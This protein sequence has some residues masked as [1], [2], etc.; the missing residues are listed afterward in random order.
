MDFLLLRQR[1][2]GLQ[3]LLKGYITV[4]LQDMYEQL[5]FK[6][7]CDGMNFAR[8]Q[9][10]VIVTPTATCGADKASVPVPLIDC[11]ASLAARM[12]AASAAVILSSD[13]AAS[14]ANSSIVDRLGTRKKR[15]RSASGSHDLGQEQEQEHA[16]DS[17]LSKKQRKKLLKEHI[18]SHVGDQKL[19]DK[20]F[21][22][23]LKKQRQG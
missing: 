12:A 19:S 1:L 23:L 6:N 14:G 8:A 20:Q 10:L 3:R 15:P 11:R 18:A 21:K 5:C 17:Q 7:A 2:Q 9:H 4:S 22:K 16:Q 13:S